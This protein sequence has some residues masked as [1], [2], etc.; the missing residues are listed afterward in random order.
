M[1]PSFAADIQIIGI[2]LPEPFYSSLIFAVHSNPF[3]SGMLKSMMIAAYIVALNRSI[4][5]AP[6]AAWSTEYPNDSSISAVPWLTIAMS[7]TT[8]IRLLAIPE[9]ANATN[10]NPAHPLPSWCCFIMSPL[11]FVEIV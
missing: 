3:I 7:S 1:L 10:Q 4:A 5:S 8:K 2:R 11:L 6:L 9:F